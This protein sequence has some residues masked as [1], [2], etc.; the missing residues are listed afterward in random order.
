M[1]GKQR[2][3]QLRY[4]TSIIEDGKFLSSYYERRS[5]NCGHI[6]N[7]DEWVDTDISSEDEEVKSICASSWTEEVKNN[8]KQHLIDTKTIKE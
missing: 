7:N 4:T 8:F 5:F 3:I 1:V 6:N 2:T